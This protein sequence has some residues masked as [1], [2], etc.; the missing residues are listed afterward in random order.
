MFLVRLMVERLVWEGAPPRRG[1]HA[2]FDT[3]SV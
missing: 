3:C 2:A 1:V